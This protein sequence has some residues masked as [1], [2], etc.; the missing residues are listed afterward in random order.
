MKENALDLSSFVASRED[1]RKQLCDESI[2]DQVFQKAAEHVAAISERN[3]EQEIILAQSA[4]IK[5]LRARV[6][7]LE[8]GGEASREAFEAWI[9]S[10]WG[11]DY[12]DFSGFGVGRRDDEWS[13]ADHSL[14]AV[15]LGYRHGSTTTPQPVK[16]P[17]KMTSVNVT[18]QFGE[19]LYNDPARLNAFKY[20]YNTCREAMLAA[21]EEGQ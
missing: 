18:K 20:G 15:W 11:S 2:R 7:E 3:A 12:H 21:Q 17:D 1:I 6:A 8:A 9:L 4:E 14:N 5:T 19:Q 16:V 10:E 13:Y